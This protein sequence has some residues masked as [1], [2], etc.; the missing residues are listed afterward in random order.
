[1]ENYRPGETI[2]EWVC[3][4]TECSAPTE[5]LDGLD[6]GVSRGPYTQPNL[7]ATL[8]TGSMRNRR[9]GL[10]R[11]T[12]VKA[13]FLTPHPALRS[14]I[15]RYVY[16][17]IG[18][19]GLWTGQEVAPPGCSVM[20][21]TCR[22]VEHLQRINDRPARRYESVILVGQ[23]TSYKRVYLFDRLNYFYVIFRPCGAYR[24]LGIHQGECFD[25]SVNLTDLLGSSARR[26][27]EELADQ[28]R[29]EAVKSSVDRFFLEQKALR[30]ESPDIVRLSRAVE[31][32][33]RRSGR[34]PGLIDAIC[35]EHGFS[36]SRL[37]RK[38]KIAVGV[39]PKM[40]QRI[41]RF[42]A[43]LRFMAARN[44]GDWRQTAYRFGYY[45]QSHFIKEFRFFYGR[46]PTQHSPDDWLLSNMAR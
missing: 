28:P 23:N 1:M 46:T 15:L 16:C 19:P 40:F 3:T 9:S 35:A 39:G 11:E 7:F 2:T 32:I 42:N 18:V 6:N 8:N 25:A 24:L 38:M 29:A 41:S 44:C 45:D 27:E 17:E 13:C 43:C 4:G 31:A 21:V 26:F 5:S 10:R 14:Y 22:G 34:G 30:R 33:R 36:I 20:C 37:E 12:N